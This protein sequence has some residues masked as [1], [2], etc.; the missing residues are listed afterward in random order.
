MSEIDLTGKCAFCKCS[1]HDFP[2]DSWHE[3]KHMAGWH[4][5][6]IYGG[7]RFC[8]PGCDRFEITDGIIYSNA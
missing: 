2:N 4:S 8:K 5:C 1:S 3:M 7:F 6:E